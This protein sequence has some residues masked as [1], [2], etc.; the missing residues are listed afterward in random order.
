MNEELHNAADVKAVER[1]KLLDQ[2]MRAQQLR[3]I[4]EIINTPS[5]LRFFRRM[6]A[7]GRVLSTTFTGNSQSYFLEGA[8]NLV[9][10][11]L[12]DVVEVEPD[13]LARLFSKEQINGG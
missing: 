5:G 4:K 12:A 1:Q 10:L 8:R 13:A 7:N 11:Y 9:N 2:R 6:I 3:D